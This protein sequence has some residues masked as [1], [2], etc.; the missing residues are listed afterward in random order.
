MKLECKCVYSEE[1]SSCLKTV[2]SAVDQVSVE[3]DAMCRQYS[4]LNQVWDFITHWEGKE[5]ATDMTAAEYEVSIHPL[6]I[7]EVLYTILPVCSPDN[8]LPAV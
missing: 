3:L 7:V 1:F 8:P 2:R 6:L 5:R 4:W